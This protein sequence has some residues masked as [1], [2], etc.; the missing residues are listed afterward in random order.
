VSH[1]TTHFDV[2]PT[3]MREYLG[4]SADPATFSVGRSLT[5]PGGRDPLVFSEYADFAIVQ[6]DRIAVVREHG[7]QI[8]GPDYAELDVALDPAVARAALEQKM[9]FYKSSE[10]ISN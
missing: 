6:Q 1:R 2:V 7:M 9:R 4:C 10:D 5:E 8:F 3:L